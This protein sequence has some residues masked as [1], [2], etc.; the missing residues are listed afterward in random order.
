[1]ARKV[2]NE[3]NNIVTS[4]SHAYVKYFDSPAN[5]FLLKFQFEKKSGIDKFFE[6]FCCHPGFFVVLIIKS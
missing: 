1:M 4:I 2:V 3:H 6:K 5:E